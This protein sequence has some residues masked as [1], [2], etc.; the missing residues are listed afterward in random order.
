MAARQ[1][2]RISDLLSEFRIKYRQN[3]KRSRSHFKCFEQ[4]RRRKPERI[5]QRFRKMKENNCKINQT[6]KMMKKKYYGF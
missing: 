1:W 6:I 2:K 5:K 4:L 3:A